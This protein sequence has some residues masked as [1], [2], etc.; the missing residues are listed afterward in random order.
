MIAYRQGY[1]LLPCAPFD[2]EKP[3]VGNLL[4]LFYVSKVWRTLSTLY[5]PPVILV[6]GYN[7][8]RSTQYK[9]S[10]QG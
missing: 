3:P 8:E 10:S 1:P 6:F 5:P 7:M 2:T 9:V 4:W